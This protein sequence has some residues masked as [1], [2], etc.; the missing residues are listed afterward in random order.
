ME[1][2]KEFLNLEIESSLKRE[3]EA[4]AERTERSLSAMIRL[5]LRQYLAAHTIRKA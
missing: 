1:D 4:L 2:E 5:I 3:L